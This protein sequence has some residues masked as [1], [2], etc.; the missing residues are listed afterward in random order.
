MAF[1]IWF[2]IAPLQSEIK[3]TLGLTKQDLWTSSIVGVAGTIFMRFVLGPMCDKFGPRVPFVFVL[4]AASIPTACTGLVNSSAGLSVLRLF[5][6]IAGGSFVMTQ[7]WMSRMFAKEIVGTA[8]AMTAG[9][10][11]LGKFCTLK[12]SL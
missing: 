10:G 8:N 12:S 3:K 7:A 4:C 11:N 6:G 2:A 9:W 1:F 5:I